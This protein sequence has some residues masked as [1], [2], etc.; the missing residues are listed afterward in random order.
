MIRFFV[1]SL[2]LFVAVQS[3]AGANVLWNSFSCSGY[4]NTTQLEWKS[5][6]GTPWVYLQIES[7]QTADGLNLSVGDCIMESTAA[8]Y[9][10]A[11][12]SIVD[13]STALGRSSYFN[14]SY[15]LRESPLADISYYNILIPDG[16]VAFL[17]L[18]TVDWHT[19]TY[20][21]G[22]LAIENYNGELLRVASAV[23]LDGGAMY[24]GGGSVPSS[25]SPEPS[26]AILVLLGTSILGLRRRRL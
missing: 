14:I 4:G 18:V 8:W 24:V 22:W 23:D 5:G 6:S 2:L 3:V 11:Y 16:E 21:Y 13:A 17:G 12:G 10:A 15:D 9:L 26:S 20:C 1:F 25:S 19:E 7:V